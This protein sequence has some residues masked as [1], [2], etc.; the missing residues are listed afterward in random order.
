MKPGKMVLIVVVFALVAP[1]LAGCA[2]SLQARK[3]DLG[4][5]VL[6]DPAILEKGT[7]DEAL[8]RYR[9]P[10]TDWKKYTKMIVDPVIVYQE[11]SL[12]AE[13]RENYQKLANNAYV[14]FTEELAKEGKLVTAPGPDTMRIQFAIVSAEKSGPVG[15]FMSTV[16]PVGMALS[17]VKYAATGKPMSVGEITGEL[18]ITDS[19]TGELLA[20]ALDK[21]VGGKQVR[22]AF[23]TWQ[24]ADSGLEYWA[25]L[26]RYRLCTLKGGASCM[27]P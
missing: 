15:N 10:K 22:G 25:A 19:M 6:V 18:R 9:N 16:V 4:K 21:R 1:L 7:G 24:D 8:Y 3:V 2:P 12:D 14:F 27:K 26:L 23:N 11:A 5:S 17:T 20:A 13:T